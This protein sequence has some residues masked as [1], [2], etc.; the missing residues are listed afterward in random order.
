ML[1]STI[2]DQHLGLFRVNIHSGI[3]SDL[4]TSDYSENLIALLAYLNHSTHR[5]APFKQPNFVYDV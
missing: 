2:H 5:L 1:N 4:A 3:W